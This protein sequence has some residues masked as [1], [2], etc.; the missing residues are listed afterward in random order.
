MGTPFR[1]WT[2]LRLSVLQQAYEQTEPQRN[3]ITFWRAVADTFE[4]LHPAHERRSGAAICERARLIG[5]PA[6]TA[7]EVCTEPCGACGGPLGRRTRTKRCIVCY[8][9]EYMAEYNKP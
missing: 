7:F 8:R 3:K 6:K 1:N 9:R 5:L 2:E 4:R